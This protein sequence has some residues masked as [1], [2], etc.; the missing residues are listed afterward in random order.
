MSLNR[1]SIAYGE[2]VE[3][4]LMFA[5][6]KF[7]EHNPMPCPC[8]TCGNLNKFVAKDVEYHLFFHGIDQSYTRWIWH[9][10]ASP[11]E[12]PSSVPLNRSTEHHFGSDVPDDTTPPDDAVSSL[13]LAQTACDLYSSNPEKFQK[14]IAEAEE[15]LYKGCL[16][17]TKLSAVVTLFN[18]KARSGWSDISF[19][20]LLKIIRDMLPDDNNLL[21]R[22]MKE[23]KKTLSVYGMSYEKI[24]AC[25]NDCVLYRKGFDNENKTSCPTCGES[26]YKVNKNLTEQRKGVPAKVLWYF[27][28]IPRFKKLFQSVQTSKQ[29]TWHAD[30]RMVDDKLRH[31]ADSPAWKLVDAKWPEFAQEPRNLRLALSA[32]GVNPHGSMS[33]KYSCWP[34]MLVTYNLPPWLYMKRKFVMLTMLISGPRQPGN[35]IDVY[36]EPLIDDLKTLWDTGVKAHDAY[37]QEAFTLK[38]VLLWTINDFPAYGNLSGCVVK[39]YHG[40]PICGEETQ[41]CRLK[42]SRKN[43]YMAHRM[44]LPEDHPFRK[45]KKAFNGE[46]EFRSAP[47]PLTGE[48]VAE[49]VNGIKTLWGKPVPKEKPKKKN[50]KSKRSTSLKRK[51]VEDVSDDGARICWK[52][53]SI[54]F[55][56]DYWEHLLLRH[57][58]DVMHIEKNVCE[59]LIGT[60]LN[61]PGKTKDGLN[62]RLDLQDM[63]LRDELA[64]NVSQNRAYLPPACFS[65]S[66]EEKFSVCETLHKLKVPDGYSSNFKAL[67]SMQD[68]KLGGMKS[69]D[70]H[71]LMQQLLPVA[72][73]SVLPKHVRVV[74]IR[75]C[76]FFNELCVK[77]VDVPRLLEV[78]K[79]L[80]VTLCL[81][82][83]YFPPSFF[84]IMVHLTIHLVREV[85]IGGPVCWRWMYGFERY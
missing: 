36:L 21:P 59:S 12:A 39:G 72:I 83:K 42:H 29:M 52:K 20:R 24:D 65:L 60:L 3:S 78:Q 56:L 15:P 37:R 58:L 28:P 31:P 49:K 11:G 85:Q 2:G 23:V 70:C 68:L 61:I 46:Q 69:H 51:R 33:S 10:E 19:S 8:K 6:K 13:K 45:Q 81:L 7:G 48:E 71:V 84:D 35:D 66:K 50:K 41:S 5:K 67:V 53:K 57:N 43:V 22:S 32:D 30:E 62:S 64:P 27:P 38:A 75:F 26:R 34:V 74:L 44:F 14:I 54:F 55:N 1:F 82:E 9:G 79:N 80:A 16:K 76:S 73:R 25:P 40:C 17:F 47:I 77:V 4:F 63:G 18:E